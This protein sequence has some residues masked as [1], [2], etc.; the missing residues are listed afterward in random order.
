MYNG[1][2]KQPS[3]HGMMAVCMFSMNFTKNFKCRLE[4][5]YPLGLEEG[6]KAHES[7]LLTLGMLDTIVVQKE[8][9]CTY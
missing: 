8:P 4:L 9:I 6:D 1:K 7:L 5:N 3:F 2:Q